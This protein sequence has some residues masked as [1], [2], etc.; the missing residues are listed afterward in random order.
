[1]IVGEGGAGKSAFANAVIG[2]PHADTGSTVGINQL[3][4]DIKHAAIGSARGWQERDRP[5][6]ELEA[7]VAN[8][9]ANRADDHEHPD[10]DSLD[11]EG[12]IDEGTLNAQAVREAAESPAA[13]S[14][15]VA[16]SDVYG[17]ADPP[18]QAAEAGLQP[19]DDELVMRCL[20]ENVHTDS[21]VIVSIYDFGGQAV[22]N[23]SLSH[24]ILFHLIYCP[25]T[26]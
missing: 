5:A 24:L 8:M 6:K 9:I 2:R 26:T 18:E 14:G 17:R 1:M 15:R 23:V 22:F 4:C 11:H 25:D 19:C 13:G 3:A 10:R 12:Q 21:K 16:D 20:A 7:A